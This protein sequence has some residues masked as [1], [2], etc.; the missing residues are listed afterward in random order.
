MA[1]LVLFVTALLVALLQ[2]TVLQGIA[3]MGSQPDLV[4]LVLLFGAHR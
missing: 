3:L 1:L 4:L 2:S